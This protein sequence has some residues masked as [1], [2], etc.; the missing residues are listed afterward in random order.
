MKRVLSAVL[1]VVMLLSLC[2]CG[3]GATWQEQYDLGVK[4][5]SEGNYEEAVIAFTAA[6]EIDP[7]QPD[8]YEKA[9]E[10]YQAMG[11]EEAAKAILEQGLEATGDEGLQA[12]LDELNQP[13]RPL[14]DLPT[15]PVEIPV[16][17]DGTLILRDFTCVFDPEAAKANNPGAVGG[18]RLNFTVEG[19]EDVGLVYIAG[20][21]EGGFGEQ[22]L[23]DYIARMVEIWNEDGERFPSG[24]QAP[25]EQGGTFPVDQEERG[26]TQQVLLVG[27]DGNGAAAAYALV[28]VDIP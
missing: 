16:T 14:G 3:G 21:Q 1:A 8:A 18:M 17:L 7:K 25:R 6:I 12:L 24:D 28:T 2:A 9:A 19:P 26:T 23:Q 27:M 10:A 13:E 20:W 4:Y 22:E 11:D 15:E 5:L